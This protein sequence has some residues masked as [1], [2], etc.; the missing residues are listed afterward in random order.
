MMIAE[1]HQH[2]GQQD[3]AMEV[4]EDFQPTHR[5]NVD[6]SEDILPRHIT[7]E[8]KTLFCVPVGVHDST[9]LA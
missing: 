8:I 1:E 4:G 9:V 7:R 5:V 3:C 6:V 2:D